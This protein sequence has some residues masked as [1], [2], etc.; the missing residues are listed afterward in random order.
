MFSDY[1]RIK[2]FRYRRKSLVH[3]IISWLVH[4]SICSLT[5]TYYN[6]RPECGVLTLLPHPS[7]ECLHP[8]MNFPLAD[9]VTAVVRCLSSINSTRF[10][11]IRSQQSDRK[12][13]FSLIHCING[14]AMLDMASRQWKPRCMQ[15]SQGHI[16]YVFLFQCWR[17]HYSDTVTFSLPVLYTLLCI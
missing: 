5:S 12:P 16:L 11:A 2:C 15:M 13:L 8:F 7:F 14:A 1:V 9:T 17:Y 6:H 3:R 4:W 10:H